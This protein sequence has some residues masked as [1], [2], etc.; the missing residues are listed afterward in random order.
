MG[1]YHVT[2]FEG[3]ED[4]D[5]SDDAPVSYVG[6]QGG[7]VEDWLVRADTPEAARVLALDFCAEVLD[8]VHQE[9]PEAEDVPEISSWI[10]PVPGS[11][12]PAKVEG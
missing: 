8:V 10:P 6:S 7:G 11:A 5:T 4:V 9:L 1:V 2:V 12:A 3:V